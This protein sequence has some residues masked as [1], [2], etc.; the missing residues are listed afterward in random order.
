MIN[1]HICSHVDGAGKAA[2]Q[3][4]QNTATFLSKGPR[5]YECSFFN[6]TLPTV[7]WGYNALNEKS[8]GLNS[9]ISN[10]DKSPP[11][12]FFGL[13]SCGCLVQCSNAAQGPAESAE[14]T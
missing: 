7:H 4:K 10:A 1:V 8:N 2:W 5:E 11:D 14:L 13:C 12:R 3:S 9:F 6:L